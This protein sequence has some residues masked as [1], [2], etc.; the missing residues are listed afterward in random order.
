MPDNTVT[1]AL[2]G[3]VT[4]E[5]FAEAIAGFNE[6]VAGLCEESGEQMEWVIDDLQY[7]STIVTG[8]GVGEPANVQKVVS[9]F[10]DVG[11][12]VENNAP[13]RHTRKVRNGLRRIFSRRHYRHSR[14]VRFETADSES[15][16]SIE[17]VN[18]PADVLE[19]PETQEQQIARVLLQPTEPAPISAV[20]T[21]SEIKRVAVS[22]GAVTGRIQTLTS[23]GG[24]RFT[25]FD[26]L[27]DKAVSCYLKEGEEDKIRNLWGKLA[28]VEGYISRDP[29]SGRAFSVRQVDNIT[30]L[31]EPS[32][33]CDYQAARGVAPSLNG[34]SPEE[35]IRRIRDVQ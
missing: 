9:G 21:A 31:Q 29:S 13:I 20:G 18:L 4:L 14:T 16:I 28:V 11:R 17:S 30:P 27:H 7:S 22:Y 26:L 23:R 33:P 1:L 15:I 6:V 5:E 24:L 35:A 3:D 8:R 2:D 12:A 25:L 10:A 32:G 34:L 19:E